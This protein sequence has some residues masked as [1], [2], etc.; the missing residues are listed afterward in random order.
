MKLVTFSDGD[1]TRAGAVDSDAVVDLHAADPSLPAAMIDLLAGGADAIARARDAI[2]S[3]RARLPLSGVTLHAPV[4]RPGKVLAI[5]LNYRDH[6]AETGRPLPERPVVFAKMPTCIVGPGAPIQRPR[7][8]EQVDFEGEL[9]VVIG[10][11]G[12]HIAAA[13]AV[14]HVAGYMI[15]NDVSVRD[16]QYHSGNWT[17]GKSFDTHGPTGPWL[18]TP[19]EVDPRDLEIRTWVNGVLKQHSNTGQLIFPVGEIIEYL[20]AAFTL[21]P[22]DVIFTGTPSGVG[23][24]RTPPE[25]LRAGDV[26]RVAISGLGVLENPVVEEE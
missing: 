22:G 9:C 23:M 18:T 14:A 11:G 21:E 19:D 3:R 10:V 24:A 13:D 4:P 20:S 6:A 26:V 7:V 12:R 1:G 2:A 25:W 15:G 5:G 16:W 17:M 8:S